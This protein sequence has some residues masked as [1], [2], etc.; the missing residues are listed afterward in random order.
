[1]RK[2]YKDPKTLAT[3]LR[4]LV[5]FYLDGV[6]TCE[7]LKEKINILIDANEER[8]YKD[9]NMSLKIS[10]IIGSSGVDIINKVFTERQI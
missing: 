8:L 7:K 3:A 5:D 1:M 10:N 9:G 4:D 6:I 2:V